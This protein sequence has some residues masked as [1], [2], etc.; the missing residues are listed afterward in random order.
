MFFRCDTDGT[1]TP[2]EVRG[3]F[4]GPM[5]SMCWIVGGGP[6]LQSMPC[7]DI[8][9]TPIP[10]FGVNLSGAGLLRPTIWTSYDPTARF[11]RSI[12]LDGSIL[13]LVSV[14]RAMDLVPKSTFKVC[15]SPNLL[16]FERVSGRG[17]HDFPPAFATTSSKED[18]GADGVV[19]WQDSLVQAIELAWWLGFR[20]L[21]FIGCEMHV[22]P[23]PAHIRLAREQG[24]EYQAGELLKGFYERCAEKGL[25]QPMLEQSAAARPYHFDETKSLAATI[26]TDWHYFRVAQYL[27]LS[28]R[29]M[30][31]AGLELISATPDSRLNDFFPFRAVDDVIET[32][33][34]R[35]GNP[36]D[37]T[38]RGKY[39]QAAKPVCGIPMRDFKPH[40]WT[41]N[42][43]SSPQKTPERRDRKARL[44]A[45]VDELPEIEVHLDEV[46]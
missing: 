25:T 33:R 4:A 10:R 43:R 22:R 26:Q 37:E 11:H 14:R 15:E 27:R 6:S 16:F 45:A 8:A 44:A 12:Y 18:A 9:S 39:S 31:L 21:V 2:V 41:D 20:E 17:F 34:H 28:R 29:A 35:V 7:R 13:K 1:R 24:V 46:G 5:R 36:L 30:A 32:M 38:T 19:D 42:R 3:L 23:E 40:G